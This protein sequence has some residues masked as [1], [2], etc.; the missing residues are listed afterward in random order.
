VYF[1]ITILLRRSGILPEYRYLAC[2]QILH[3]PRVWNSTKKPRL[4]VFHLHSAEGTNYSGC[5]GVAKDSC[6]KERLHAAGAPPLAFELLMCYIKRY[7]CLNHF[8]QRFILGGAIGWRA[9]GRTAIFAA[10]AASRMRINYACVR[11]GVEFPRELLIN[12]RPWPLA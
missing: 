5:K 9:C 7:T 8:G 12:C 10:A 3:S 4:S 1:R 11:P 2:S 6:A